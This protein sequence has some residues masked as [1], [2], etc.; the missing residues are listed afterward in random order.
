MGGK[1]KSKKKKGLVAALASKK[2]MLAPS[3][4]LEVST[5]E[6]EEAKAKPSMISWREGRPTFKEC[7]LKGHCKGHGGAC[8]QKGDC[9][10]DRYQCVGDERAREARFLPGI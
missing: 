3:S 8:L 10:S 9:S 4:F 2:K 6:Q 5:Q 1:D 7:S